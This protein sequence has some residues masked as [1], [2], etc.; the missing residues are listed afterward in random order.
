MATWSSAAPPA[1]LGAAAS[2]AWRIMTWINVT[3]TYAP[4]TPYHGFHARV[5]ADHRPARAEDRHDR[6]QPPR[7]PVARPPASP[8]RARPDR[9]LR[10]RARRPGRADQGAPGGRLQP[11]GD[12]A[13]DRERGRLDRGGAALHAH[14]AR[15]VRRR[16]AG[17]LDDRRT[18]RAVGRR[19]QPAA[20]RA[21]RLAR[22]HAPA[23]RRPR[24][25]AQPAARPRGRGA[26]PARHPDRARARRARIAAAARRRRGPSLRRPV[27]RA[28]LAAVRR[29]RAPGRALARR[30]RG[31]RAAPPARRRV[32]AGHV[33]AGHDRPCGRGGGGAASAAEPA[34]LAAR[35]GAGPCITCDSTARETLR[36]TFGTIVV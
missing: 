23:R 21:R 4:Y 22:P 24:G 17:D 28:G 1:G 33:P 16:G 29:R 8:R 35:V 20:A 9:L 5:R 30:A 2:R 12:P 25:G 10:A 26:G 11:R 27:P 6:A 36:R 15:R 34:P 32:T 14:G 3:P 19:R 13:P 7:T 18:G 31:A